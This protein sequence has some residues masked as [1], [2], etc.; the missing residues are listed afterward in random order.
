MLCFHVSDF[1]A[2]QAR[3]DFGIIGREGPGVAEHETP[4][5]LPVG[6]AQKIAVLVEQQDKP[7]RANRNLF[8]FLHQDGA[9][10][11]QNQDAALGPPVVKHRRRKAN[12]RFEWTFNVL[13]FHVEIEGRGEKLPAL[14]QDRLREIIARGFRLEFAVRHHGG[15]AVVV[16]DANDFV[17]VGVQVADLVIESF[18]TA[19]E[20]V[21]VVEGLLVRDAARKEIAQHRLVRQVK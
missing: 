14:K 5:V 3:P 9:Q 17:P 6:R 7:G 8:Q 13:M 11:V 21:L 15:S 2:G 1:C 12:D 16:V 18:V 19:E 20:K 10:V 4:F